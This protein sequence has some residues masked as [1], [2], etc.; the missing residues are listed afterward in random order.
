MKKCPFC[1][2]QIQDEA[3]KCRY[4]ASALEV[5]S[6]IGGNANSAGTI[7]VSAEE[8]RR[9]LGI[10]AHKPDEVLAQ[11]ML[12]VPFI[13]CLLIWF[14]IGS[15]T[16]LQGPGSALFA[17]TLGTVTVTSFLAYADA[18]R[19]G[20]G[21]DERS[22]KES[23]PGAW[24]AFITLLW[25]IGYPAYL[26]HRNKYGARSYLAVGILVTVVFLF[27][28]Y[29]MSSAIEAQQDKIRNLLR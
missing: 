27:S 20:I 1:A 29:G 12:A 26:H 3:I 7:T 5:G 16:L 14:W 10:R 18:R 25:F 6:G 8:I 21:N 9:Q 2:E 28:V 13:S 4:C 22:R 15:M 19:L 23:G 17:V 24:L 11:S